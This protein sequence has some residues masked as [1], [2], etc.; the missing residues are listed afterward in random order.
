[1]VAYCTRAIQRLFPSAVTCESLF[2]PMYRTI[3]MSQRSFS[4]R[5]YTKKHEWVIVEGNTAVVGISDFAQAALGD[6][7]YAELPEIG[8][9][10]HAG[11]SAGAVESV[12]AASDIYSPISGTVTEKNIEIES[13]PSLI[14]KSALS[15]GWL[16]KLKLKDANELKEL[17][18]EAAYEAFKKIEEAAH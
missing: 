16:Y 3:A 6:I 18:N 17:M 1:M 12:K 13:N 15:K 7:V 10:L 11:D 2:I 9:E 14:N 5:Y 4:D 8:K